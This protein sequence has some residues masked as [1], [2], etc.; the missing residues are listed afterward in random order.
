M[1]VYVQSTPRPAGPTYD[2]VL[3][4]KTGKIVLPTENEHSANA[5]AEVLVVIVNL[6][7]LVNATRCN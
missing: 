5:L 1:K 2:C 3:W 7:S 6:L 4:T